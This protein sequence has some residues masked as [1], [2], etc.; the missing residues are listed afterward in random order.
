MI[1]VIILSLVQGVTEFLPISSSSHLILMGNYLNFQNQNLSIDV[2]LHIGSFLAVITYFRNEIKNFI[3][4][5]ELF[6]KILISSIPVMITGYFLV[7]LNLIEQLRN[8]KVIGWTTI[9]FGIILYLSDR[10][11]LKKKFDNNFTYRSA[12]LIGLFQVLSLVP[13]VSRS[14]IAISVARFLKYD[15]FDASKIS[16]LISIP[17]LFA[18][19]LFGIKN[20]ISHQSTSFSILNL[21]SILFSYVISFLTIKFFLKYIKKFSLNVFII[22]RIILGIILLL[23]VYL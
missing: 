19:S 21:M 18:L 5:K 9:V 20:L 16:F 11:K 23:I 14:G 13:G 7:K 22:Y 4:N 8:I 10:Y 6:L 12:I 2:S 15:R 17:I 1:E 3:E